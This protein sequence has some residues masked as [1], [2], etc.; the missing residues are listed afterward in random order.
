[1]GILDWFN[2]QSQIRNLKWQKTPPPAESRAPDA[3]VD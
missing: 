2:P 1:M 3:A